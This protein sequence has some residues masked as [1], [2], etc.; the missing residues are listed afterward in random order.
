[1]H[2]REDMVL[3]AL[4]FPSHLRKQVRRYK[5]DYTC[6]EPA[7]SENP[8]YSTNCGTATEPSLLGMCKSPLAQHLY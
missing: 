3:I 8:F 6:V 2:G 1:M 4:S 7:Q 5:I